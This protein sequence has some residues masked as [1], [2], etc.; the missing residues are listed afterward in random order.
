MLE[1]RQTSPGMIID[2]LY[3]QQLVADGIEESA[4]LE[5]KGAA[6]VGTANEIKSEM[7]KD[8]SAF[9][10]S[11]GGTIIYG[12]KEYA[13]PEKRHLPER[14]D[15]VNRRKFTKEWMDQL[16]SRI[17][18]RIDG[19]RI[20]P[21]HVGPGADDYCYALEIPQGSTAHQALD[22]RYYKRRN[23]ES[24]PME[25]YE[26]RDVMNRRKHPV[27]TAEIRIVSNPLPDNS[28]V[29]LRLTNTSNVLARFYRTVMEVPMRLSTGYI[30]VE[31]ALTG[32]RN[33]RYFWQIVAVPPLRGGPLFPSCPIHQKFKFERN[34]NVTSPTTNQPLESTEDIRIT[35]WADEMEP[36]RLTK[37][38][39]LAEK[40]WT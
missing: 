34:V 20:T 15:P 3:L 36:L 37:E 22:F 6:S 8:I 25:D 29:V 13:A 26:I 30:A 2:R 4:S 33:G 17:Q 21:V 18:P 1:P 12:I 11:A 19:L 28:Y 32:E 38:L 31:D 39:A 5:Y 40:D 27:I 16:V 35:V 9:A 23:F 14:F 10:N 7:T 24:T